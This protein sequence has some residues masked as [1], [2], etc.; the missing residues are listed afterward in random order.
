MKKRVLMRLVLLAIIGTSAAF[1]QQPT[2]DKL[3]WGT[4]L[5]VNVASY[6]GNGKMQL[7]EAANKSISGAVV[8]PGTYNGNPVE[9]KNFIDCAGI[10][11]VVILDDA[12]SISTDAF[13]GCTNL[14][15]VTVPASVNVIGGNAFLNCGK[16][17]SVALMANTYRRFDDNAFPG[18]LAK[19][20][21]SADGGA[22]TYTRQAGSNTWRKQ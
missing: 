4:V 20:F 3:K 1:A 5:T 8:I 13:R 7:V 15:S 18:D 2:L 9:A 10:T 16:L 14:T 21:K 17:T 6:G 19:V 12:I 22:G 11:S